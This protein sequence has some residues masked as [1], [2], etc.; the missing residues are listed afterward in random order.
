[1]NQQ[2]QRCGRRWRY[3]F[4]RRKYAGAVLLSVL[5]GAVSWAGSV[6][7]CCGAEAA[8]A[9]FLWSNPRDGTYI[10][11]LLEDG[12]DKVW[13][14]TEDRGLT[15][16]DRTTGEKTPFVP[17]SGLPEDAVLALA[18]DALGRVWA[19]HGHSGVSVYNGQRWKN[20]NWETGPLGMRVWDIACTPEDV[21][22]ATSRGLAR[23]HLATDRWQYYTRANGLPFTGVIS[24]TVDLQGQLYAGSPYEGVAYG[25]PPFDPERQLP[26]FHWQTVPAPDEP[27]YRAT[28]P[29][30][31]SKLVNALATGPDGTIYIGT[32]NGLAYGKGGDFHYVRGK[33]LARVIAGLAKYQAAKKEAGS[34]AA[35]QQKASGPACNFEQKGNP[36]VQNPPAAVSA[37]ELPLTEDYVNTVCVDAAGLLYLGHR[38]TGYEVIRPAPS[39]QKLAGTA[40]L[41]EVSN[42]QVR[43]ARAFLPQADRKLLLG[44]YGWGLQTADVVPGGNGRY[45]PFA[46]PVAQEE[47]TFPSFCPPP[48]EEELL[49]LTQRFEKQPALAEG[50]GIAVDEDW[51]TQGNWI[52]RY[53]KDASCLFHYGRYG[54]TGPDSES[55]FAQFGTGR[56]FG[57][58]DKDRFN[59]WGAFRSTDDRQFLYNPYTLTREDGDINGWATTGI[60][61][62]DQGDYL[63]IQFRVPAG[64][65]RASFFFTDVDSKGSRDFPVWLYDES[66]KLLAR[67][68][69]YNFR[70]SVYKNFL[71][72]G[73]GNYVL[74]LG[75]LG[76]F[77]AMLNG[78]FFDRV[79][80]PDDPAPRT[81]WNGRLP[82]MSTLHCFPAALSVSGEPRPAGWA[83]WQRYLDASGRSGAGTAAG[84]A[85]LFFLRRAV[86]DH[87]PEN[88]Q[89]WLRWQAGVWD[90]ADH[91]RFSA[92]QTELFRRRADYAP[93]LTR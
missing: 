85:D 9:A 63:H 11:A 27:D 17:A 54:L 71:L 56:G 24:V 21:W 13:V 8:D 33:D 16:L 50:D 55:F 25:N 88:W 72:R 7:R 60:R 30:L 68:R 92:L 87:A 29:G 43:Q 91:A 49:R 45:L 57:E 84:I 32:F 76:C 67:E 38:N 39:W 47:K 78:L 37:E 69:V 53:G 15:V 64:L 89:H 10:R 51:Q 62:F 58:F 66:G 19:G 31:P 12:H 61:Y 48:T 70:E 90:A 74:I 34:K 5:L 59:T 41:A 28:G 36:G 22:L 52:G 81:R 82:W 42:G 26:D 20:Y 14:A 93:E 77:N 1:M 46:Y 4:F 65:V 79:Q 3:A 35:T 6:A 80:R 40:V 73:P 83:L 18:T 86:A 23:Y 2:C 75:R 44:M